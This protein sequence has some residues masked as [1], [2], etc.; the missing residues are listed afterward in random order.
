MHA[1]KFDGTIAGGEI[2]DKNES[3]L[4]STEQ[5]HVWVDEELSVFS[6]ETLFMFIDDELFLV[7]FSLVTSSTILFYDTESNKCLYHYSFIAYFHHLRF[8]SMF[9]N[10]RKS[11]PK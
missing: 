1:G 10:R 7:H 9:F 5:I 2:S 3:E 4:S 11:Y 8:F 6:V